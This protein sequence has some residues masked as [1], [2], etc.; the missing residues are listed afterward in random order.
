MCWLRTHAAFNSFRVNLSES[1]A[2]VQ[3]VLPC[4][5]Q[6]QACQNLLAKLDI[7]TYDTWLEKVGIDAHSAQCCSLLSDDEVKFVKEMSRF[8]RNDFPLTLDPS[9]EAG[10]LI[11]RSREMDHGSVL[12]SPHGVWVGWKGASRHVASA[13]IV[14]HGD[15]VGL[16]SDQVDKIF[17]LETN[18]EEEATLVYDLLW[19]THPRVTCFAPKFHKG[20]D[21]R[22]LLGLK[23]LA[24]INKLSFPLHQFDVACNR[25]KSQKKNTS[26]PGVLLLLDSHRQIVA[27]AKSWNMM[28][29]LNVSPVVQKWLSSGVA[30]LHDYSICAFVF[31]GRAPVYSL[32]TLICN[33]FSPR[34]DY[35]TDALRSL[36]NMN[37]PLRGI[38]IGL[39]ILGLDAL[40]ALVH[41]ICFRNDKEK[42]SESKERKKTE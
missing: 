22:G 37:A 39:G 16:R 12:N 31:L 8:L 30:S 27:C 29:S 15:L 33:R 21:I 20:G 19:A 23:C 14:D 25:M 17:L 34:F 24:L 41:V 32:G 7:T 11:R 28:E 9:F 4:D 3:D 38:D 40:G 42:D 10:Q 35:L 13:G 26:N 2:L 6:K 5:E 1:M 36:M 18:T